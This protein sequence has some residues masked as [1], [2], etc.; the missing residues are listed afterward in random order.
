MEGYIDTVRKMINSMEETA[1]LLTKFQDIRKNSNK[2]EFE[3]TLEKLDRKELEDL[4]EKFERFE[5]IIKE[6][7]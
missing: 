3:A 5:K 1:W 7:L 2:E 6:N 4:Q